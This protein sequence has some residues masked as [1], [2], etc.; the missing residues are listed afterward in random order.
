MPPLSSAALVRWVWS[1]CVAGFITVPAHYTIASCAR[2]GASGWALPA[3]KS[4][5][6]RAGG[7]MAH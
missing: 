6:L 3:S 4:I 7:D 2:L 1:P 5:E